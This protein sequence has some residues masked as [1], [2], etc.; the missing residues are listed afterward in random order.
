MYRRG[1]EPQRAIL[2]K[3]R[4][5][6]AMKRTPIAVAV[7]AALMLGAG[8]AGAADQSGASGQSSQE[9]GKQSFME[10]DSNL[11]GMLSHNEVE[12]S[13]TL[14]NQFDSIDAN[15]DGYIERSEFSAWEDSESGSQGEKPAPKEDSSSG[16]ESSGG[17][18]GMD[19][20]SSTMESGSPEGA[21]S[22]D[23]GEA[24]TNQP[25]TVSFSSL[26]TNA[27]KVISKE[28]AAVDPNLADQF[29]TA[30]ANGDGV[31]EESEFS[32]FE[33]GTQEGG[34]ST[35][36]EKQPG[37]SDGSAPTPDSKGMGGGSSRLERDPHF[38]YA[39]L[40][41]AQAGT[42]GG[43]GSGSGGTTNTPGGSTGV[44][45]SSTNDI[46]GG[47]TGSG[48]GGGMGGTTSRPTTSLPSFSALDANGDGAISSDEATASAT[49]M[50]S[51]GQADT[52]HDGMI[53]RAEFSALETGGTSGGGAGGA[54][55]GGATGT[56]GSTGDMGT[57]GSTGGTMET[58][59][60]AGSS[61]P[62]GRP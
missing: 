37:T 23:T 31:I 2:F 8:I 49:L 4:K 58:V 56:P 57:P 43:F 12:P 61:Q 21:A 13:A 14:R 48:T 24:H 42:G 29:T 28:E 41:L 36:P 55:P 9:S 3:Q 5:E 30:D 34:S 32:A 60:P 33:A 59:P 19:Q 26:D 22:D 10:L 18:G 62:S 27:D 38:R 20:G 54:Y 17:A 25:V 47:S 40:R 51:F 35:L 15:R 44:P 50:G 7:A 1:R 52:N 53:D 6:K 11:D 45:G 46:P 39:I 16:L